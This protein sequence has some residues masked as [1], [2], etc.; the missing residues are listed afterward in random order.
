MC[1]KRILWYKFIAL[2]LALVL[3]VPILMACGG[4]DEKET[5]TA[6]PTSTATPTAT[7]TA[8][9]TVTAT[10]TTNKEPVKLGAIYPRSGQMA[11]VN[12]MYEPIVSLVERQG[13]NKGGNP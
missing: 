5:Y 6:V 13:K 9:T 10:P 7:S 8:T 2:A 1:S 11:M 4:G 3:V 12:V